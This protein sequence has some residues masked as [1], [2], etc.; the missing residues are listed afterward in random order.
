M[1]MMLKATMDVDSGNQ[2]I[3]DGSM[4]RMLEETMAKLKP[5]A[6]Y[7]FADGGDR[8]MLMVFDMKD[9]SEIPG[10]VEPLFLGINAQVEMIPVMNQDDLKKG[11]A[12]FMKSR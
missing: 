9:T 1:R 10:I 12:A 6:A 11:L 7:F 3:E 4:G 2:A 8:S 5:E